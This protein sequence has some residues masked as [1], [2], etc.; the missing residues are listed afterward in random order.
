MIPWDN[1]AIPK[2]ICVGHADKWLPLLGLQAGIL[3]LVIL[4]SNEDW[5]LIIVSSN[6]DRLVTIL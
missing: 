2:M 1:Q 5:M 4:Y 3:S 6:E